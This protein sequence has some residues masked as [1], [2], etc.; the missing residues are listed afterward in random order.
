MDP[1]KADFHLLHKVA[2]RLKKWS[3]EP[4]T[5]GYQHEP[6]RMLANEIFNRLANRD[7]LVNKG[8]CYVGCNFYKTKDCNRACG[9]YPPP[10]T[11]EEEQNGSIPR[12]YLR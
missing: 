12:V 7:G 6:M 2:L 9:N 4:D 11:E 10:D 5:S 8:L 1:R 3:H